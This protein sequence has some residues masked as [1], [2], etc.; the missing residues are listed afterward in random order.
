MITFKIYI[1]IVNDLFYSTILKFSITPIDNFTA[2]KTN[3]DVL[4]ISCD[5]HNLKEHLEVLNSTDIDVTR[6]NYSNSTAIQILDDV[7]KNPVDKNVSHPLRN[8]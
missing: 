2:N 8:I 7:A 3:S 1:L 5:S 4:K 6:G